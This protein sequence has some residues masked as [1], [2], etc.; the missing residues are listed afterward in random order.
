MRGKEV[1]VKFRS[2]LLASAIALSFGAAGATAL[3]AQ[4]Q[5]TEQEP[6]EVEQA[7]Q[8]L[9]QQLVNE[10]G[11]EVG[12]IAEIAEDPATGNRVLV[13]EH[14]QLLGLGVEHSMVPMEEVRPDT[15]PVLMGPE[16]TAADLQHY[17]PQLYESIARAPEATPPEPAPGLVEREAPSDPPR[18]PPPAQ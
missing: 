16:R 1:A 11:D 15:P 14:D 17:P 12:L 13:I 3:A 5:M 8:L 4:P 9:G 7:Q 6:I 18:E 2:S 10:A